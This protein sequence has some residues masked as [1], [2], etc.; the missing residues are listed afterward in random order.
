MLGVANSSDMGGYNMAWRSGMAQVNMLGVGQALSIKR[1]RAR[2][3]HLTSLC[4]IVGVCHA[5]AHVP[6]CLLAPV[7]ILCCGPS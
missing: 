5:A 3:K 2:M 1:G 4:D 7:V 6:A